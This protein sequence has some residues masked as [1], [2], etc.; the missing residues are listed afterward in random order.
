M[1]V[2][3]VPRPPPLIGM[4]MFGNLLRESGV[5]E[6]LSKTAQNELANVVTIFLGLTVGSTM[7]A[8]TFVNVAARSDYRLGAVAFCLDTAGGVL[9]GKLMC[10]CRGGKSIR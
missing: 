3:L 2:L 7:A 6:R 1:P 5:V 4:L 8:D 10:C 9:F